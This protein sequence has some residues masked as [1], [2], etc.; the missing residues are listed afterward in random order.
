M[1]KRESEDVTT[2]NRHVPLRRPQE[3][4]RLLQM[5]VGRARAES[6][7]CHQKTQENHTCCVESSNGCAAKTNSNAA[8]VEDGKVTH[9]GQML[10]WP[11]QD[12]S[13][14]DQEVLARLRAISNNCWGT[15]AGIALHSTRFGMASKIKRLVW[16]RCDTDAVRCGLGSTDLGPVLTEL[17]LV[18][19]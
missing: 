6:R 7:D 8:W 17:G 11:Q 18:S 15:S 3:V 19:L 9:L 2:I 14:A 16:T 5:D 1:D 4:C 13:S 12:L 10:G